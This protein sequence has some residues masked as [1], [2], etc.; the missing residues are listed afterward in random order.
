MC[1]SSDINHSESDL[2]RK[3]QQLCEQQLLVMNI[4]EPGLSVARGKLLIELQQCILQLGTQ[5][6]KYFLFSPN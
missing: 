6:V 1:N 3:K 2:L 5:I 4:I